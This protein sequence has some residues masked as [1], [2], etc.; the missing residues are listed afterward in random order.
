MGAALSGCAWKAG[1]T[2]DSREVPTPTFLVFLLQ[3]DLDCGATCCL[4]P[5]VVRDEAQ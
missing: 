3:D 2:M 5:Q 4:G 1:E